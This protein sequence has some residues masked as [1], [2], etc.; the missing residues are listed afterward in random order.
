MFI[1]ETSDGIILSVKVIPRSSRNEIAGAV[2][3]NL[4]IKITSAPE[5]GKA[6]KALIRFLS[7]SLNL[8]KSDISIIKGETSAHKLLKIKQIDKATFIRALELCKRK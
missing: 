2:G 1:K 6:N 4:K 5:K 8:V 3:D 7:G